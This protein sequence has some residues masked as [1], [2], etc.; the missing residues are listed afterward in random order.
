MNAEEAIEILIEILED[1]L[2]REPLSKLQITV[3][4]HT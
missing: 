2:S 1:V 3:F 4:R